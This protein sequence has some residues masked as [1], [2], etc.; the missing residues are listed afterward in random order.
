[1]VSTYYEKKK[2]AKSNAK[3]SKFTFMEIFKIKTLAEI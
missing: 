3:T 1:M 2:N